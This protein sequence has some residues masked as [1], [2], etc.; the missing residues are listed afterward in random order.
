MARIVVGITG[1]SGIILGIRAIQELTKQCK[2][3]LVMTQS[4]CLTARE[5]LGPSFSS[6][7]RFLENFS[8]EERSKIFLHSIHDFRAPIASGSYLTR[9]MLILPCSMTTVAAISCGLSDT[10]LRRA[11]D[12]TL[13]EKRPLVLVPR[14]TPFNTIHLQNLLKLSELGVSIVPPVPAWYTQPKTLQD[15][16]NFIVGKALDALKIHTDIFERWKGVNSF[17]EPSVFCG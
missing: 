4:A 2:V 16:E 11:A 8:E 1:A 17:N 14:E 3:D 9:G 13:K 6:P 12:V 7:K 5:E 10:V 15:V